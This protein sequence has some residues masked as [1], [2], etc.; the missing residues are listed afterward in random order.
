MENRDSG[1]RHPD[2]ASVLLVCTAICVAVLTI[3]L[4]ITSDVYRQK[5][6]VPAESSPG[7]EEVGTVPATGTVIG[8]KKVGIVCP[9][10]HGRASV[11]FRMTI[12][13][14]LDGSEETISIVVATEETYRKATVGRKVTI[15]LP[16]DH[17]AARSTPPQETII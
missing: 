11:V 15:H 5:Y 16:H 2:A 1:V 3:H 9:A 13:V 7:L 17:P 14:Q 8:K 12:D 6:L 4:A 10:G